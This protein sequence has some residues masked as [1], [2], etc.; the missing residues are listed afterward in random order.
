MFFVDLDGFKPVNDRYGHDIGDVVL[1]TVAQRLRT[2]LRP[3]DIV[4][5]YG[6]DEFVALCIAVPSGEEETVSRRIERVLAA[7][8]AWDGGSWMPRASI[9]V[10]RPRRD[11]QPDTVLRRADEAMYEIKRTRRTDGPV[12]G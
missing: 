8:I 11:D 1:R 4:A 3:G 9:G 7:P 10:A 2:A 6:G 12:G 5:R